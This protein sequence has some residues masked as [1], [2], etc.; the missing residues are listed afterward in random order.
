[1]NLLSA[2]LPD[3]VVLDDDEMLSYLHDCVSD[4]SFLVRADQLGDA[5]VFLDVALADSPFTGGLSPKLGK[6][7][8]KTVSIRAFSPRT[9]V[10]MLD[11]LNDLA[12]PYRWVVRWLPMDKTDATKLLSSLRR[13]W[14]AKRKGMWAL[15]KEVITKE[16]SQ[17]EDTD[18]IGKAAETDAALQALGGDHASYGYLTLTITTRGET[19]LE[20]AENARLIQQ[21]IDST[22]IVS[23]VEDF[24][25]VQAW[26]GSLPG[27]AYA[28]V[29]R[30]LVN[31]LNLCDLIP[32][33]SVWSGPAFNAHLNAPALMHT[34]ARGGTAFRLDLHQGD[35]GHTL[36]AGPTGA[37]RARCST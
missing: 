22:G 36:V 33:S 7:F 8:L 23:Q 5:P 32:L 29:R 10:C 1:M 12:I 13:Q 31:S 6:H 21:V 26:L 30:P 18:A 25:A 17:L 37:G 9:A 16:P 2:F 3:V 35:V 11:Q 4:R 19:E 27:H 34:K 28:D 14:F 20:A 15:L 24:N